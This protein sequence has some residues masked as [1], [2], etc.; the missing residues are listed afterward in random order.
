[1]PSQMEFYELEFP[2]ICRAISTIG[3]NL[4]EWVPKFVD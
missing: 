4:K 3:V 1:M 2:G